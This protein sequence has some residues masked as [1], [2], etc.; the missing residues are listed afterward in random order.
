MPVQGRLLG[1]D[2]GTKRLGLAVSDYEQ[3][4]ACPLD[5]RACSSDLAD[6]EYLR[7]MVDD[8]TVVGVVV[9]LPVH[10]SGDEGEAACE[11]RAFGEW[12]GRIVHR[13]V[14]FWDE[15]FSSAIADVRLSE[16]GVRKSRRAGLRDQLA[17]QAM[18]QSFLDADDRSRPPADLPRHNH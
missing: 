13:P 12:V 8:Y 7:L 3:R 11:A 18:L 6:A 16:A 2:F 15:R 1:L 5:T 4:I 17:A 14:T 10:M 9:G